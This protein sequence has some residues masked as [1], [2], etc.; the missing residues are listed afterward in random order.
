ML[1][2]AGFGVPYLSSARLV[3]VGY[4][5]K[6]VEDRVSSMREYLSPGIVEGNIFKKR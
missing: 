3:G 5:L 6:V 2:P 1:V 4:F